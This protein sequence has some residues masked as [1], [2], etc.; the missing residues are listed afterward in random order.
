MKVLK[1]G[2]QINLDIDKGDDHKEEKYRCKLVDLQGDYL[3]IDYPVHT[4]T[5]KTGF[6]L[7]GAQF[8]ASFVGEDQ[9]V[10]W[11]ETEIVTRK[12]LNIPVIVLK[13][14]GLDKLDR[15]QRRRYV[16]VETSVDVS[17][18]G[19]EHFHPTVTTDI[20][21]GGVA[22]IQPK[23]QELKEK[24]PVRMTLVLGM[25]SGDYHYI[26]AEGTVVRTFM[27]KGSK[28]ARASIEFDDILD[29]HRQKIIQFCFEQ[30]MHM[31]KRHL[32]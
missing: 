32:Q 18:G 1:I 25:N 24:D 13:F 10:Y 5:G 29:K 21:G 8:Q 7:D 15:I 6:F 17:V 31:R 23:Q 30:Q 22:L 14:P 12:K 28:Q 20:S 2:T 19:A 26:E 3:F 16:R 4:L 9:S 27:P 11:F